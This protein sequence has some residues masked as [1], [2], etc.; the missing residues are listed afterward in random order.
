MWLNFRKFEARKGENTNSEGT[1]QG[2]GVHGD[3]VAGGGSGDE[4]DTA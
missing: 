1:E 2:H 4:V 3:I